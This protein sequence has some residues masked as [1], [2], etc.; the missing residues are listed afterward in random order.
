MLTIRDHAGNDLVSA[1]PAA[2]QRSIVKGTVAIPIACVVVETD[3]DLPYQ[4]VSADIDWNDGTASVHYPQGVLT[5]QASPLDLQV[6]RNLS[7]GTYAIRVTAHN[8]RAIPDQV[9]VTF[10]ATIT[11]LKTEGAPPRYVFGPILPRDSG[12]PNR[13]TWNYDIGTDL[14]ILESSVR[15]LLLTAKGERLMLPDYGTNLRQ[16]LFT[17]NIESVETL[18][19]HEITEA[20]NRFEPRVTLE[21]LEIDRDPNGRSVNVAATFLSRVA[22]QPFEINLQM[23]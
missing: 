12:L 7:F 22:A 2:I 13:A 19:S 8:N 6:S 10:V 9:T 1:A 17:P 23:A 16:I 20:L 3:T 14:K 4:A 21:S 18:V 5:D 15:M 11:P